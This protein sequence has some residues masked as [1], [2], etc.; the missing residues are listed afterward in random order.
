MRVL[1]DSLTKMPRSGIRVIMDM[2]AGMKEVF[3]MELGEPGFQTPDHIK[4]AACKA[5][6]DGFT[7]YTANIGFLSLR[8]AVMDRMRAD[9]ADVAIEQI[10]IT[11]G[12]VFALA[13]AVM[14]VTEPGG[15]VLISDPGWPNYS[16]QAIAMERKPVFYP[17]YEENG[18]EPRLE[19]LEPLVTPKTQVI[20]VNS[21]SN[22]T[23]AVYSRK[24]CEMLLEFA[25]KHDLTI[26]S[27]EVYDRIIFEGE[28]VSLL[29]LDPGERVI[30][31]GGASKTYSMTGW[32]V[33][34]Y[35]APAHVAAHMNKLLEPYASCAAAPSQ[36]AAEA[37]LRGPQDCVAEMTAAY[38]RRRDLM[39]GILGENGFSYSTP[40][41]AFYL[42][43]NIE[44]AGL[45]S[46]AFCKELLTATGVACAPGLTFGKSSDGFV[47]FSF[48]ADDAQI[49]EG[50]RRFCAF[51]KERTA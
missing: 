4:E 41:G 50:A 34:W 12:S 22:P 10:A 43:A 30:S 11:P 7:K 26:I 18:F 15:E 49:E 48:C 25:R 42:M 39:L 36:K 51:Y 17:L 16:M 45:D 33:G 37:A 21:P 6:R 35:S 3:H 32:R 40:R 20:V 19:D 44:K 27:D 8:E 13:A 5:I 14:A 28:H 38:K 46:Y 31:V 9:G 2:A 23:G 1:S 29:S 24:T 47:R